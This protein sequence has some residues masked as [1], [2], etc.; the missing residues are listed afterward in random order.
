MEQ[1][2]LYLLF[3]AFLSIAV[4]I[5]FL[6][7]A[8]KQRDMSRRSLGMYRALTDQSRDPVFVINPGGKI[9]NVNDA[10]L[11]WIGSKRRDLIGRSVYLFTT[12]LQNESVELAMRH[13]H[14]WAGVITQ[15]GKDGTTH[16]AYLLLKPL[17]DKAGSLREYIGIHLDMRDHSL[18]P[19]DAR[20]E[21]AV[22]KLP[23][24][25]LVL[26]EERIVFA[27]P[28][29]VAI[30]GYESEAEL[31]R[32]HYTSFVAA[33]SR[34]FAG[35]IYRNV[36]SGETAE[37]NFDIKFISK[38]G[39]IVDLE[40]N[41]AGITWNRAPA[42]LLSIRDVA[43]RKKTEREQAQWLWE[44]ELLNSVE[45]QLVSTVELPNVLDM[46]VYHARLLVRADIAAVLTIDPEKDTYR[47][48][49]MK[50]H[51]GKYPTTFL[52][53][54][55]K[56]K[57]FYHESEPKIIQDLTD[58]TVYSG[59]DF[60]LLAA[61][62]IATVLQYP[63]MRGSIVFG[64]LILGYRKHYELSDRLQNLVH[65][66]TERA[67][68]AI[69]NAELYDQLRQQ[70]KNLQQLF[71]ARMQAQ[72]E[73]R[74]RIAVELHDSLGQLLTS[75]K[76]HIEV[77]QD[78][79]IFSKTAEKDQMNEIRSLLDSAITEAR[80]ISYDLRPSILDDF[81]LLPALEVLCEKFSLR[82]GIKVLFRSHNLEAR[83]MNQLETMLYRITQ[84]ALN[85]VQKH[86]AASEVNVQIIRTPTTINLVIE[87]N[88]KGFDPAVTGDTPQYSAGGTIATG[89]GLVSMRERAAYFNGTFTVDSTPGK[90]TDILVEIPLSGVIEHAKDPDHIGR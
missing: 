13:G 52:S 15:K 62:N 79:D 46:I 27:N 11:S 69:M 31:T 43:E 33:Q 59:D 74:R 35:D 44:Q 57:E 28:A 80:N 88:G 16:T 61:E 39:E 36:L 63:L 38:S 87:D 21:S 37:R 49:A 68:V 40:A 81:G 50:G 24:G 56:A 42:V 19:D 48:L 1:L 51:S 75:I 60:P 4:S 2:T 6:Y 41:S 54:S 84:E 76:L 70:T 29:A 58:R 34:A 65:S 66:F 3:I 90:G 73:E 53:L 8:I 67:T 78:S 10:F 25:V 85:N 72:E 55:P 18:S 82:T 26:Q 89:M 71:D 20:Y 12:Y 5:L 9:L 45:R 17:F 32:V 7:S 14:S 22:S 83:L 47:W 77:L 64:H 30:L 86:A 23:D